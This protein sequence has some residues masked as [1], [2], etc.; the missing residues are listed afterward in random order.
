MTGRAR[1]LVDDL[2]AIEVDIVIDDQI[3]PV[4]PRPTIDSVVETY[5]RWLERHV[6]AIESRWNST[7]PTAAD[8]GTVARAVAETSLRFTTNRPDHDA[9]RPLAERAAEAEARC[10]IMTADGRLPDSAAQHLLRRIGGVLVQFAAMPRDPEERT[11]DEVL[12]I[13]KA[14]ELG[15]ATIS[16]QTVVQL[17]GDIVVRA[18][19]DAF[20]AADRAPV[21]TLHA[22]A[23]D[24]ALAHWR[25]LIGFAAQMTMSAAGVATAIRRGLR[26]PWSSLRD[27]WNRR[28]ATVAASGITGGRLLTPSALKETWRHFAALRRDLL[29]DGGT[30]IETPADGGDDGGFDCRTVIQADGDAL[31]FVRADKV[32]DAATLRRHAEAVAARYADSEEVVATLRRYLVGLQGAC[33]AVFAAVA[34]VITATA[35]DGAAMWAGLA[36]TGVAI[37]FVVSGVRGAIGWFLRRGLGNSLST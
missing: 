24:G 12:L 18:D 10:R 21:R 37:G 31:W 2:L 23:V 19:D 22:A 3:P 4:E 11:V 17:D 26:R 32:A 9:M 34:T 35:A 25:V 5:R 14:A 6:P 27:A 13:R 29:D 20:L 1:G 16:A 15:T 8:R 28:R 30:T 7:E 33:S 36:A